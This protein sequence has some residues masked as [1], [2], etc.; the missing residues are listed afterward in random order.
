MQGSQDNLGHLQL[1]N[2]HFPA[3]LW[4]HSSWGTK[5][6]TTE[7]LSVTPNNVKLNVLQPK[8]QMRAPVAS[9]MSTHQT[10]N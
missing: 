4:S 7:G 2:E 1:N 9:S 5:V 10:P 3:R 8:T 6:A